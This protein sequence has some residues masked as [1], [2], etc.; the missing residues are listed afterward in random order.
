MGTELKDTFVQA[1]NDTYDYINRYLTSKLPTRELIED[2]LQSVYLDFYRSLITTEGK[3]KNVRHYVL[4]IAKH[5]VAD[6]Y[7]QQPKATFEDITD[8]NIPDEKALA[9]LENADFFDYEQVMS[10]LKSSDDTTYRIFVLHYQYGYTIKKT[11][12]CLG[13]SQSTVKSRLYRTL[14]KLKK[15]TV[16]RRNKAMKMTDIMKKS[17]SESKSENLDAILQKID[18]KAFITNSADSAHRNKTPAY[19]A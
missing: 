3:I 4:R 13:L 2:A 16:K 18:N 11:A 14:D 9:T 5:Y 19:K 6:H 7:R 1:Y 17:H 8:L 12:S 15:H 10:Y